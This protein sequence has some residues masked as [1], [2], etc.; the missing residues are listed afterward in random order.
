MK[1]IKIIVLGTILY[2]INIVNALPYE[3][4]LRSINNTFGDFVNSVIEIFWSTEIF[5]RN[6]LFY[7][8]CVVYL[9]IVLM[10]VYAPAKIYVQ[11]YT[12]SQLVRK[13]FGNLGEGLSENKRLFNSTVRPVLNVPTK[14]IK[15]TV[16]T[17]GSGMNLGYKSVM[18]HQTGQTSMVGAIQ[19]RYKRDREQGK[20]QER[21]GYSEEKY[22]ERRDEG[23]LFTDQ[24]YKD[25]WNANR[26]VQLGDRDERR[27]QQLS[28]LDERR[29]YSEGKYLE[30]REEGR[31]YTDKRYD[32]RWN[33]N[34]EVKLGDKDLRRREKL[35]EMEERRGY[36]RQESDYKYLRSKVDRDEDIRNRK[37]Y[38]ETMSA[39]GNLIRTNISEV[40]PKVKDE[41]NYIRRK[42]GLSALEKERN[43]KKYEKYKDS[44]V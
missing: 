41:F 25:R 15:G 35:E 13:I 31:A 18:A 7:I 8:I 33:F 28:D 26:E 10:I 19:S 40:Q 21:R 36:N 38:T 3:A 32:D 43:R 2:V 14:V 12:N 30:R 20:L 6:I 1:K 27:K 44:L 42:E 4:E 5:I 11:Y 23:R 24:R 22:L 16:S 39:R 17:M 29:G 34:R 9:L 37:R